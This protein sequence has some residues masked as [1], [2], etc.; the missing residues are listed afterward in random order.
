MVT[1]RKAANG[2]INTRHGEDAGRSFPHVGIDIG[3]G[4]GT[5]L[6][7][8]AAGW[9]TWAWVGT[10]GLR[11]IIVHDD[12]TWSLIAHA[13]EFFGA[14]GR[15]VEAREHI[16]TMGRTGGPW[17]SAGWYVH[18][19]Q[20][21]HLA[22]GR[23]VDPEDYFNASA[24]VGVDETPVKTPEQIEEEELMSAESNIIAAVRA[25]AEDVKEAV[26]REE[27]W[28]L[29]YDAGPNGV[30][31]FN[32]PRVT[33]AALLG[34]DRV[35]ALSANPEA[36]AAEIGGGNGVILTKTESERPMALTSTDF[37]KHVDM[38]DDPD[39]PFGSFVENV[40]DVAAGPTRHVRTTYTLEYPSRYAVWRDGRPVRLTLQGKTIER[41]IKRGSR[42]FAVVEGA[43]V[44]LTAE[45]IARADAQAAAGQ[46]WNVL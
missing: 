20:E 38:I 16:G 1:I 21:Y 14:N 27:R 3:W 43:E 26:R 15:R 31:A 4:G 41:L 13:E 22:N 10:Y 35:H 6:Y 25:A 33:R 36:R 23:A 7:A 12:G 11:C 29:S 40:F 8:P 46:V 32:D 2:N 5:E 34:E 45:Q 18:C 24:P 9:M 28:R 39:A 30:L 44:E 42:G 19:H 37:A 17:G